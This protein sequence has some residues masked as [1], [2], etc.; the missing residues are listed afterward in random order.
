MVARDTHG[1]PFGKGA[2]VRVTKGDHQDTTGTVR[3]I[4]T[5]EWADHTRVGLARHDREDLLFVKATNV[6]RVQADEIDA[7]PCGCRVEVHEKSGG[8]CVA[9]RSGCRT[10]PTHER[11][12]SDPDAALHA[13]MQDD[14]HGR[15]GHGPDADREL[16]EGA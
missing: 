4:G 3:W 14:P 1:N 13:L 8:A 10:H 5:P 2:Y 7:L 6:V 15:L 11:W 16:M 9:R 12:R